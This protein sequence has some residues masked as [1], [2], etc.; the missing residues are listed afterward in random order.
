MKLKDEMMSEI[1]SFLCVML[2]VPPKVVDFEYYDKDMK[3]NR[4]LG[5][6]PQEFYNKYVNINLGDYVSIINA[7]TK[8]I[9]LF[10]ICLLWFLGNVVGGKV[11]V[12]LPIDEFKKIS[13]CT[14]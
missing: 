9:N 3:F 10:I 5:L 2:G 12:N 4:D 1:Y 7:T 14:N 13:N 11:G 8:E 6:T